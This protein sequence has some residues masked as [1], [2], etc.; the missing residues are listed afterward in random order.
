MAG[1]PIVEETPDFY[2]GQPGAGPH[3]R[4]GRRRITSDALCGCWAVPAGDA[5]CKLPTTAAEVLTP[6]GGVLEY[7]ADKPQDGSGF[8]FRTNDF[9]M[10]VK[11]GGICVRTEQA[12]SDGDPVFVRFAA[13]DANTILGAFRKDADAGSATAGVLEITF[14]SAADGVVAEIE[15]DGTKVEYTSSTT[16]TAAQKATAFAAVIDALAA[17]TAAAVGALITVTKA[18]GPIEV[19]SKSAPSVFTTAVAAAGASG[20]TA[21]QLP[22]FYYE[23]DAGTGAAF[24]KVRG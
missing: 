17:Y 11:E 23:H 9:V 15:L 12:V 21:A 6:G 7:T 14:V 19:G 1:I 24:L 18:A 22:G 20:A 3:R 2:P 13:K 16:Q 4:D 8:D 5:L 10:R